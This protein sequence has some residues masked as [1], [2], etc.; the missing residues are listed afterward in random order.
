MTTLRHERAR[1]APRTPA[2]FNSR[3]QMMLVPGRTERYSLLVQMRHRF[4]CNESRHPGRL[5]HRGFE[6][7]RIRGSPMIGGPSWLRAAADMYLN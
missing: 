6:E 3:R 4:T 7:S 2:L 1:I 5:D